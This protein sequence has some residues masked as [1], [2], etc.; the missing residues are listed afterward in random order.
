MQFS[1]TYSR[2]IEKK[3]CRRQH[4]KIADKIEF[5]IEFLKNGVI[6]FLEYAQDRS[7]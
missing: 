2:Y 5:V 1:G 3:H 4:E 6:L 7:L